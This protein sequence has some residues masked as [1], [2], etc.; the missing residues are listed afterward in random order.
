MITRTR[1]G[2]KLHEHLNRVALPWAQTI[3]RRHLT[4]ES[5]IGRTIPR[6][7]CVKQNGTASGLSPSMSVFPSISLHQCSVRILHSPTINALLS[8]VETSKT[9][10]VCN[11]TPHSLSPPKLRTTSVVS[12]AFL[13]CTKLARTGTRDRAALACGRSEQLKQISR[14]ITHPL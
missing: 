10:S 3:S 7:I 5:R 6:G 4:S 11:N 8:Y 12:S 1:G 13:L 9:S 2:E 14:R